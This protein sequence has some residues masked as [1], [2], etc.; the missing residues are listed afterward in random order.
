MQYFNWFGIFC[1]CLFY[2]FF[3]LK[4]HWSWVVIGIISILQL[5][6]AIFISYLYN[7]WTQAMNTINTTTCHH[8]HVNGKFSWTMMMAHYSIFSAHRGL[9]MLV[10][11]VLCISKRI[12]SC[13]K[14]VLLN[15]C[16]WIVVI[17]KFNFSELALHIFNMDCQTFVRDIFMTKF[18]KTCHIRI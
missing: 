13:W 15:V 4:V 7:V 3:T 12:N 14:K 18:A 1:S 17:R 2:K 16:K 5:E 6:F 10:T 11:K 8:G 9:H